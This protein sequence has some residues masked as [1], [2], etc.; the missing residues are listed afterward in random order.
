[1][2]QKLRCCM[3]VFEGWNSSSIE[4]GCMLEV[5][6]CKFTHMFLQVIDMCLLLINGSCRLFV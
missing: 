2:F 5:V 6:S 4:L 1:M 3:N